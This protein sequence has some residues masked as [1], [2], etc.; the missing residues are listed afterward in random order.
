M[1]Q[2]NVLTFVVGYVASW[3]SA[4]GDAEVGKGFYIPSTVTGDRPSLA[5]FDLA[6]LGTADEGEQD[7]LSYKRFITYA[8]Q[9]ISPWH[10][11]PFEAGVGPDGEKLL[12]FVCEIPVGTNAKMEVNKENEH[13]PIIQ[14]TKKGKLRYYKY[15]PE[16]GSL[17]NYGAI[18]Q[19]WE[20]PELKHPDTGV[21]GDNDPIDVLQ[22]NP[23]PC[24]VGEVMAVRVIGVFALVDDGET[25][26]KVL[27]VRADE[28]HPPIMANVDDVPQSKKTELIEWFRRY[29]TAEGKGLNLF[30]LDEKIMDKD[31]AMGV[32]EETHLHWHRMRHG[33]L[34]MP[35][36]APEHARADLLQ[37]AKMLPALMLSEE[38]LQ[39]VHTLAE[40]WAS[41]LQ[42]FMTENQYLQSLHYEHIFVGGEWVPMPVPIV[43]SCSSEDKARI[44]GQKRIALQGPDGEV[45][46]LLFSPEVYEHR[47]EERAARTFGITAAGHPY[48][49]MIMSAG[50]W[51]VGGRVQV[52]RPIVYND[53]MDQ[54]RLTPLQLRAKFQELGADAV[55]AF[56]LRNPV[57]NGHALLMQDTAEKLKEKGFKRPVLWLSPLGGWTKDDDVPLSVRMEQHRAI[58]KNGVFGDTP[59]VLAIFPSPMLYAGPREVQWHAYARLQGGASHYIV[60]RDPAGMKHPAKDDDIYQMW[61]GQKMLQMSPGLQQM[62]LLP[63]NFASYDE[64]AGKMAFFDPR[65]KEDFVSISGSKMRKLAREGKTPPPGFMDP[66]G[67]SILVKYYQSLAAQ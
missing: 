54:Y 39:W 5:A 8:G 67:W 66:E 35:L 24:T 41:P 43:K 28:K 60:G 64:K 29:K 49:D 32:C 18:A 50:D 1:R 15:N 9:K 16:V 55:F 47:K 26:W 34:V 12:H 13:N 25:D 30:G 37:E 14:D 53:G 45:V 11:V 3:L 23:E 17:V 40:G 51:L 48:I 52:L 36:F 65:R 33:H 19:T 44:A 62:K 21:G 31:F 6:K 27:V 2:L 61:H 57:H 46:A 59:V 4:A 7:T 20:H 38:E 56:Q 22:M 63:F 58:I 10:E 42:G